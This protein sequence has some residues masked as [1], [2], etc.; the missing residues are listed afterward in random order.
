[1]MLIERVRMKSLRWLFTNTLWDD[2]ED[3]IGLKMLIRKIE[4]I[5]Y[6]TGK[7]RCHKHY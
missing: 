2:L 7:H 3:K 5:D 6:Q 1:M 4:L